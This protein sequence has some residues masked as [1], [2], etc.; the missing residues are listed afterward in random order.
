MCNG[1]QGSDGIISCWDKESRQKSVFLRHTVQR[2]FCCICSV[3]INLLIWSGDWQRT[4]WGEFCP[5]RERFCL[6]VLLEL[7]LFVLRILFSLTVVGCF[8]LYR[9]KVFESAGAPIADLKFSPTST[10]LAYAVSY[11][12]HKVRFL[13]LCRSNKM[14]FQEVC[15]CT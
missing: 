13:K 2:S 3:L 11:D 8:S 4:W 1:F 9:V 7:L 12:W 10:A 5:S 15:F 14:W 6:E